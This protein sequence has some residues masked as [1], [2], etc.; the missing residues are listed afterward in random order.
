MHTDNEIKYFEEHEGSG[1]PRRK[2]ELCTFY[3]RNGCNKDKKDC[4]YAHGEEDAFCPN[5][6]KNGHFEKNCT[7]VRTM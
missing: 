6:G 3:A 1:H 7:V 4:D 5:C 2:I